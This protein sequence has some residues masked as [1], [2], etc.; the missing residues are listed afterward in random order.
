[1]NDIMAPYLFLFSGVGIFSVIYA[2]LDKHPLVQS[3]GEV[4]KAL[5]IMVGIINILGVILK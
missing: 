1:M 3:Y 4:G 2:W 5:L